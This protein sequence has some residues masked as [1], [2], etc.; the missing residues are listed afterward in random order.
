[1]A[2]AVLR[3]VG[4]GDFE[5]ASAGTNPRRISPK[6]IRVLAEAGIETAGARSKS[7]D[8]FAG[9]SFDYVVT[10]CDLAKEAC[11]VIPGARR[12]FHWSIPDPAAAEAGEDSIAV[13]RNTLEDVRDRVTTFVQE[14]ARERATGTG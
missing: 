7:I 9:S 11:P 13:F 12:S 4:G 1:M 2:E 8:E 10:V 5:V 6:A 14:A 3:H